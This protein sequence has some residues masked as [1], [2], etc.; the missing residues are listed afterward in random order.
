MLFILSGNFILLGICY[1]CST[2]SSSLLLLI[3]LFFVLSLGLISDHWKNTDV[4]KKRLCPCTCSDRPLQRHLG[5]TS[6]SLYSK[7]C[8]LQMH[9]ILC[10]PFSFFTLGQQ[11]IQHFIGDLCCHPPN[12]P[13]DLWKPSCSLES[14]LSR[15]CSLPG[16][17]VFSCPL[18]PCLPKREKWPHPCS[19]LKPEQRL[20]W[21]SPFP[22]EWRGS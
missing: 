17:T 22:L 19:Q 9:K 1:D 18:V 7:Y 16:P 21:P 4:V 15:Q 12:V 3:V 14:S 8:L 5:N 2:S 6:C 13:S 10:L 20:R 11:E